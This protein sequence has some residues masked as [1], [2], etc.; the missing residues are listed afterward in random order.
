MFPILHRLKRQTKQGHFQPKAARSHHLFP[1][2]FIV[3]QVATGFQFTEGPVWI[4]SKQYLLF[5]DIP[6]NTIYK[7]DNSRGVSV[8]RAPSHHANG[9]TCDRQGQ[10]IACEHGSRSI[11]RTDSNGTVTVLS[12]HFQSKPLNSP[13]DVVVK[14][15]GTLY[16]TDPPYGIQAKQQ[17]QPVQGVYRLSPDSQELTLVAD[18][19]VRPN[20]LAFSPDEQT[21]YISD[22]SSRCHIRAFDVHPDGSLTNSRVFQ[23]MTIPKAPGAPDGMK[24][25]QAGRLYATGPG[26]VWILEA[27][28]THLGTVILPEQPANCAWGDDNR[29]SLYI[30]AQTSVYKIRVNTPG[31][32]P[33]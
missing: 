27:D 7:L 2:P 6:A 3:E 31:I 30:T 10:L 19:F 12:D 13:N 17:E 14:S 33:V 1:R 8:F 26:G 23:T 16:F 9:L 18:D 11:T 15:D 4:A 20:G 5:S 28:G 21:L 32:D 29:Q 22:S 25:D 24:V